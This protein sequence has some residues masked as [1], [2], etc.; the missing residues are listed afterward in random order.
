VIINSGLP[1][2]GF[3][4]LLARHG[5]SIGNAEGLHQGQ[6]DFPLNET[7]RLQAKSLARRL[8]RERRQFDLILTSP[9]KRARETADILAQTLETPIEVDALWMERDN[10]LLSGLRPEDAE[11]QT[12]RPLFIHPYQPIGETGESQWALYIRASQAVQNL[13]AHPLGSYLVISHGGILNLVLYAILGIPLQANFTGPR[14][15]FA[16]TAFATLSYRPNEHKWIVHGVNDQAH[17]KGP[18]A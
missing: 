15:R 10:G 3:H 14:F 1:G 18:S 4:I 17:W 11:Q 6:T 13:L 12:P 5:E 8:K 7:G 16:N 2:T 9:L